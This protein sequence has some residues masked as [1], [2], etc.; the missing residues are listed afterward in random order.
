M[1][2]YMRPYIL[3]NVCNVC[4]EYNEQVTSKWRQKQRL[5]ENAGTDTHDC[6]IIAAAAI[7][8]TADALHRYEADKRGDGGRMRPHDSDAMPP[9]LHPNKEIGSG[10]RKEPSPQTYLDVHSRI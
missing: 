6:H 2:A 7:A 8:A 3:C 9:S 1:R 10:R 4:E 5:G